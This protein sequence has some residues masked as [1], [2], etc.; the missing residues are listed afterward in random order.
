MFNDEKLKKVI[1]QNNDLLNQFGEYLLQKDLKIKTINK[2]L[3]NLD[4]FLNHFLP[5]YAG[6]SENEIANIYDIVDEF[7]NYFGDWYI[8]KV[9]Y[10]SV[11]TLKSSLTSL[12]KFYKFLYEIGKIGKVDLETINSI[13][14]ENKD[15]WILKMEMYD[16]DEDLDDYDW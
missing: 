2:H 12:K 9:L 3:D 11:S 14:K 4:L 16:N 13:I 7:D 8:K 6:N 10:S 5:Y 1:K 15:E